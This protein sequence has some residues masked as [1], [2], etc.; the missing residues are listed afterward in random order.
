MIHPEKI[1]SHLFVHPTLHHDHEVHGN[2]Q[3]IPKGLGQNCQNFKLRKS[4]IV[5][6]ISFTAKFIWFVQ[7][8]KLRNFLKYIVK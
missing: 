2:S 1:Y 6:F 5:I 4:G 8:K 7:Y 3:L